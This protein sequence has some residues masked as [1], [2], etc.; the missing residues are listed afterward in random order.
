M[1]NQTFLRIVSLTVFIG[2]YAGAQTDKK[3]ATESLPTPAAEPVKVVAESGQVNET[4]LEVSTLKTYSESNLIPNGDF[5]N[6]LRNKEL[7]EDWSYGSKD[8]RQDKASTIVPY[9]GR[10]YDNWRAVKQ[11]WHKNDGAESVFRQFGVTLSGLA[12]NTRYRL[13]LKSKNPSGRVVRVAVWSVVDSANQKVERINS[14]LITVGKSDD[15]VDYWA[16]FDSGESDTIRIVTLCADSQFPVEVVW[17]KFTLA[18]VPEQSESLVRNGRLGNWPDGQRLPIHWTHAVGYTLQNMPS[19][20]ERYKGNTPAPGYVAV[21][22]WRES[23]VADSIYKQFGQT[24]EN[25]KPHTHYRLSVKALN[26]S[27]WTAMVAVWGVDSSKESQ[28]N[29]SPAFILVRPSKEFGFLDYSGEF[30]TGSYSTIRIVTCSR[31]AG[32]KVAWTAF[33]MNEMGPSKSP[34]PNTP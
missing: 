23:D 22:T 31:K 2:I 18:R 27:D 33:E 3:A 6:W 9:E 16:D 11:T 5:S 30:D 25:L 21:Q 15:L 10:T 12:K 14:F 28:Q 26:L 17:D 32:T 20:I 34:L 1:R 8:P 24:I 13:T 7:P 4:A 29:L 19:L